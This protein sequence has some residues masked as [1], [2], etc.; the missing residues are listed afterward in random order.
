M[1]DTPDF[2]FT[3]RARRYAAVPLALFAGVAGLVVAVTAAVPAL[4]QDR[5]WVGAV[6]VGVRVRR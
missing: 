6:T 2:L 4:R 1:G 3:V 5:W